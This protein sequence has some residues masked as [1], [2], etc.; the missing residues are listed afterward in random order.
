M[1]A[2]TIITISASVETR[3]LQSN[4]F[5]HVC[6]PAHGLLE[7]KPLSDNPVAVSVTMQALQALLRETITGIEITNPVIVKMGDQVLMVQSTPVRNG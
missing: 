1:S 6:S 3:E 5:G 7:N 4:D 2:R